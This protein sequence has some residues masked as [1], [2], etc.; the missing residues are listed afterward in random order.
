[1]GVKTED[2][3]SEDNGKGRGKPGHKHSKRRGRSLESRLCS[4]AFRLLYATGMTAM[5]L[6]DLFIFD[7]WGGGWTGFI[8]AR[9]TLGDL[10]A[11]AV[12][13]LGVSVRKAS[14]VALGEFFTF[15]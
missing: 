14:Y 6:S 2:D 13:H 5:V 11:L 4:R 7:F 9:W 1:M 3:K 8:N 12:M 10:I 15:K